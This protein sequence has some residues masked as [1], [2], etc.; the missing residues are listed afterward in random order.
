MVAPAMQENTPSVRVVDL[1][2]RVRDG[3][4]R[5]TVIDHVS[6]ALAR[7]ELALLR[8][9]SGS[10]KTTLLA[11]VGALLSPTSGEVWL[12]GEA[13]SRLR[14][15]QRAELRRRK[16]GFVFQDVQLL[17]GLDARENVLLPCVPDG[18]AEAIESRADELLAR[19]GVANVAGVPARSL[20]G[21]ERQ[22]VGLARALIADPSLLLLDEPTA[23]V[24]DARAESIVRDLAALALEGR[25][26]LVAT[27]D[28]RVAALVHGCRV[29]DLHEG[30]LQQIPHELR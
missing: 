5:R 23:H 9:P 29:L 19:F 7:G 15:E 21:G 6:F 1:V 28:P 25:A 20:S 22:R 13:T 4:E 30:V 27:H 16:V 12:D 2:K 10:G 18:I 8:G 17:D 11:L 24:D 3:R 26:L 14:D